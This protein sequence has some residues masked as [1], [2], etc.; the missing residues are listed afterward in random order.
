MK[1][2]LIVLE[3]VQE[4]V[5]TIPLGEELE[6][7]IKTER[8]CHPELKDATVEKVIK[9]IMISSDSWFYENFLE[10][11]VKAG[12]TRARC[13]SVKIVEEEE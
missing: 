4:E 6:E 10:D 12:Y 1:Y 3:K 11:R 7:A 9:S 13:S 2:L 5:A 8:E